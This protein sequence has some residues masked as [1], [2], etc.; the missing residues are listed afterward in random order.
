LEVPDFS[1]S[2]DFSISNG[3]RQ[4]RRVSDEV[5]VGL[6]HEKALGIR[7]VL[8]TRILLVLGKTGG[9]RVGAGNR[10]AQEEQ[11]EQEAVPLHGV[12]SFV[13]VAELYFFLI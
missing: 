2:P 6:D 5:D 12:S 3:Y 11:S 13:G 1:V 10:K 9:R 8:L 4:A 7:W